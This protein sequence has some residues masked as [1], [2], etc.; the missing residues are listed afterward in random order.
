MALTVLLPGCLKNPRL[1]KD[2]GRAAIVWENPG[3]GAAAPSPAEKETEHELLAEKRQAEDQGGDELAHATTLYRLAILRRQQGNL[4]EAENLYRQAL[5]IRERRQGPAHPDVAIILN[6][7]AAVYAAEGKYDAA[8]PLL[9]R[10]V[11]IRQTALGEDH[12]R[13]AE[14]L[15]NLALLYAAQGKPAAAEQLYRRAITVLEKQSATP[16]AATQG[17]LDRVLEN[18]AALLWDTGRD[19]EAEAMEARVRLL[20]ATNGRPADALRDTAP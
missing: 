11:E 3:L 6:N 18:Y 17:E 9:E 4:A 16:S 12:V 14:S 19:R 2:E 1:G 15:N 13:T 7:L 5:A 8:Q 10:S 20:R